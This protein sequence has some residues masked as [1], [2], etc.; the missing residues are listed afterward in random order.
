MTTIDTPVVLAGGTKIEW[1]HFTYNPWWGCERVSRACQHCL[2]PDTRIMRS[3]GTW[4]R[5]GDI[6]VGD[7]LYGFTEAPSTGQNRLAETTIVEAV[8]TTRSPTIAITTGSGRTVTCSP[9]HLWL[10][11]GS[12]HWKRAD[13]LTLGM[14]LCR[15]SDPV[16]AAL[17]RKGMERLYGS[18]HPMEPDRI[19]GLVAGP[20]RD[21]VDIT[22]ST[23][24][25]IAEGLSTHNCYAETLAKRYGHDVWGKRAGRRELSDDNWRKPLKWNR[26]AASAGVRY[27]VFCASM[28]DVFEGRPELD[29]HRARLWDLIEQTPHLDWMLLTKRPE[30]IER[31]APARWR[32]RGAWPAHAWPGTTTEDQDAFNERAPRLLNVDAAV[33]FISYEPA[34]GPLD[35]HGSGDIAGEWLNLVIAGGE[36]G[37]GARPAHPDWFRAVRD[38]CA[39]AGVAFHFKQ[40]GDWAPEG[41][42]EIAGSP[43]YQ[44]IGLAGETVGLG[45]YPGIV[46]MRRVG[47]KAAGRLL[48]G[49]TWDEMPERPAAAHPLVSRPASAPSAVGP[50]LPVG[51]LGHVGRPP[52][53][54]SL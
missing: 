52:R 17:H 22:T 5:I 47:K 26:D 31:L 9:N 12:R 10:V 7:E 15:L 29:P 4:D 3:D 41:G 37:P 35:I 30:N 6:Q 32:G 46:R 25:F 39:A 16:G 19:V 18:R 24:T 40:W 50:E 42:R 2:D 8:W 1:A 36:T 13:Q 20:D 34:M 28:A 51:A 48:D 27:R 54:G 33:R 49:R 45:A 53:K 43:R 11:K 38:Q 44:D 14:E 23:R 21:L